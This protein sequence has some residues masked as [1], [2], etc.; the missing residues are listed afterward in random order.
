MRRIFAERRFEELNRPL[1]YEE[2]LSK[3]YPFCTCNAAADEGEAAREFRV[4]P[5]LRSS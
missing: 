2:N 5:L 1:G 3:R 4:Y